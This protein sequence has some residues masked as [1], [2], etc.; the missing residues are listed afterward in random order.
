M[1][2]SVPQVLSEIIAG[3]A[4]GMGA[5]ARMLPAHRGEGTARPSTIWRWIVQG[6][7]TPDG[8][9]VKLEASRVGGRWLTSRA[10]LARFSAALTPV[11]PGTATTPH[12][13]RTPLA[14]R[15]AAE[16]AANELARRGA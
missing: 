8:S 10:A 3:D 11:S 5:A 2:D 13:S 14:R 9:T 1:A 6:V 12:R 16:A 4:L 7:R 15:K